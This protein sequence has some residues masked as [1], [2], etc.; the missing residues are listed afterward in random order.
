MQTYTVGS[1][2]ASIQLKVDISTLGLAASRAI[3][4]DL[5][6]SAPGVSVAH[7]NDATGDIQDTS[8]GL[9]EN[10]KV[11]RLSIYTKVDITG[12]NLE[13]RK[14]EYE[15]ISASYVLSNG[16][17]GLV[18]YKEPHKNVDENYQ[19]AMVIQHIDLI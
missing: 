16:E 7:S 5:H 12:N 15:E 1:G 14:K 2:T 10:L 3:V 17:D 9:P 11:R 8:I 4:V 6:S 19:V 13:L 18:I